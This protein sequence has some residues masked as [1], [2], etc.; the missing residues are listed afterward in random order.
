MLFLS[1]YKR[2]PRCLKCC[3]FVNLGEIDAFTLS[4][5][6]SRIKPVQQ[7][8]RL[9]IVTMEMEKLYRLN[10]DLATV[11]SMQLFNVCKHQFIS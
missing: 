5:I 3:T 10:L 7:Y 9:K 4:T 11:I 6:V 2:L 8:G 1:L